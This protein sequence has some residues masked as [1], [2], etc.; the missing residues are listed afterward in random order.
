MQE[1]DLRSGVDVDEQ[2]NGTLRQE[3]EQE[4]EK[5]VEV[6]E[7][8]SGTLRFELLWKRGFCQPAC[9]TKR[10]FAPAW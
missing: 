1:R 2:D 10:M 6:D 8:D 9:S 3:Q 4:K 7:Q 5:E